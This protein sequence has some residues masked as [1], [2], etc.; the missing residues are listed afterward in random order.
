MGLFFF[1]FSMERSVMTSSQLWGTRKHVLIQYC[2]AKY[3]LLMVLSHMQETRTVYTI[4]LHGQH[5][6]S[7]SPAW[8]EQVNRVTD[9]PTP[10]AVI[11][12]HHLHILLGHR[13]EMTDWRQN[14]LLPTPGKPLVEVIPLHVGY[15][16]NWLTI[17]VSC[18]D[19]LNVL[20]I[21]QIGLQ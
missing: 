19:N 11:T 8:S 4:A 9:L 15:I 12:N 17:F 7:T 13:A 2:D 16:V 14:V 6:L 18:L 21:Q 1:S 3:F 5:A 20:N 10:V